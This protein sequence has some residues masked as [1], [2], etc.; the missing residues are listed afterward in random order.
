MRFPGAQRASM[1]F[2][3]LVLALGVLAL[4]TVAALPDRGEV[5]TL[6]VDGA[7][8]FRRQNGRAELSGKSALANVAGAFASHM[9]RTGRYSHD[10]DG[11]SPTERVRAVGYRHCMVA[12]N[13]AYAFSSQGF[14]T[15]ELAQRFLK[16][17]KD[18]PGHRRNLLDADALETGVGVARDDQG[19]YYAVQLFARPESG[20]VRFEVRNESR[21][22]V[23]YRLGGKSLELPARTVRAHETCGPEALSFPMRGTD[24]SFEPR[25]GDRFIVSGD[26]SRPIVRRSVQG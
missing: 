24:P 20:R 6:I 19:R 23:S 1:R 8:D 3:P 4:P 18:S 11:R 12:E 13:I 7:N 5:E 9:A 26:S 22:K 10:A 15:R 14:E 21:S 17:W 16:G 2:L 25:D